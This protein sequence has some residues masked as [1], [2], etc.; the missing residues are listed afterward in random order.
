MGCT[1][2]LSWPL[3]ASKWTVAERPDRYRWSPLSTSCSIYACILR[4]R[5]REGVGHG[6]MLPADRVCLASCSNQTAQLGVNSGRVLEALVAEV[7]LSSKCPEVLEIEIGVVAHH[8]DSSVAG[9]TKS[10][11]TSGPWYPNFFR[12][13]RS[14]P[15]LPIFMICSGDSFSPAAR[16]S[17]SSR[18][19]FNFFS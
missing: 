18:T 2:A 15:S 7:H 10:A 19:A 9:L 11:C 8:V 13:R 12:S 4:C 1:F 5:W 14:S 6:Q 16:F 17:F 3:S